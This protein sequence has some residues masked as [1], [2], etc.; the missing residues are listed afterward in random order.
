MPL[1]HATPTGSI[2]NAFVA[3]Q[4]TILSETRCCATIR[5]LHTGGIWLVNSLCWCND[6]TFVQRIL[7]GL[8]F[9][10]TTKIIQLILLFPCAVGCGITSRKLKW[11]PFWGSNAFRYGTPPCSESWQKRGSEGGLSVGFWWI[12]CSIVPPNDAFHQAVHSRRVWSPD[13]SP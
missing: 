11:M 13:H 7:S 5:Q 8:Q 1:L 2:N 9:Q 10:R 4:S 3:L 12:V 6:C